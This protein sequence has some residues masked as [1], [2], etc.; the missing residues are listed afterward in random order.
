MFLLVRCDLFRFIASYHST[1]PPACLCVAMNGA[2]T[3]PSCLELESLV[4]LDSENGV[5]RAAEGSFFALARR[6][7]SLEV[8]M[9]DDIERRGRYRDHDRSTNATW[10]TSHACVNVFV[11]LAVLPG[12]AAAI[13]SYV[14]GIHRT[15]Y[16][17]PHRRNCPGGSSTCEGSIGITSPRLLLCKHYVMDEVIQ[18]TLPRSADPIHLP[19]MNLLPP[20]TVLRLSN[21]SYGR[22]RV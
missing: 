5:E 2:T 1:N 9:D 18:P 15:K 17:G 14:P 3:C 12:S 6:N 20:R 8:L 22:E 13:R 11:T 10:K 7:F 16:V 21:R 19:D 4:T